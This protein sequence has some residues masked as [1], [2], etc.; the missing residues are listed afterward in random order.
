MQRC[1][2]ADSH[3]LTHLKPA[4]DIQ[5]GT[6][7][8]G[9]QSVP[10]HAKSRSSSMRASSLALPPP[11]PAVAS[12][13]SA[14]SAATPRSTSESFRLYKASTWGV[15]CSPPHVARH[16]CE[17]SCLCADGPRGA[18]D[19]CLLD[20]AV[21]LALEYVLLSGGHHGG[22]IWVIAHGRQVLYLLFE[23]L[24]VDVV[25]LPVGHLL[26]QQLIPEPHHTAVSI[27]IASGTC[28]TA[29]A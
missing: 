24:I 8:D 28:A 3:S 13:L 27:K 11:A 21:Q 4:C 9:E 22:D 2:F 17:R 12:A 6:N 16:A 25:L 19:A 23:T 7:C 18:A 26:C 15:A 1:R 20:L 5:S 10:A 29:H 14:F